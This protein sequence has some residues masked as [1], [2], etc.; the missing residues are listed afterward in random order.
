MTFAIPGA[1][2]NMNKVLSWVCE[3]S[4][5]EI[6]NSHNALECIGY[7]GIEPARMAISLWNT[8]GDMVARI[9]AI[10][11][12]IISAP[13]VVTGILL[14]QVGRILP[15]PL[16]NNTDEIFGRISRFTVDEL[17]EV[18][19]AFCN[20]M[21]RHNIQCFS[22]GGTTLGI[23]RHGGII[24]WDNDVDFN[25]FESDLERIKMAMEEL[26]S[27]GW[28]V[29]YF[30][31]Q[32]M[33]Q[34]HTSTPHNSEEPGTLDLFLLKKMSDNKLGEV[35]KCASEFFQA[36]FPKEYYTQEEIDSIEEFPF[37]P[38]EMNLKIPSIKKMKRYLY[39]YYGSNC[40]EAGVLTHGHIKLFGV[41]PIPVPK[42]DLQSVP[43][44]STQ[45]AQ[46]NRWTGTSIR[47]E[48]E[49]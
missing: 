5:P 30:Q 46:G 12:G 35:Y 25:A 33:Y 18:T 14:R 29:T 21:K 6:G 37:G 45:C 20:V 1:G 10:A 32:K 31:D 42:F 28:K 17:Y 22:A 19:K 24:P 39:T 27:C 15:H 26:K 23:A 47:P 16:Q 2:V 40:L 36:K 38:V 8:H 13:L 9:A 41:I 3:D 49:N 43:I 48:V 11:I 4:N 44:T 34:V 7:W